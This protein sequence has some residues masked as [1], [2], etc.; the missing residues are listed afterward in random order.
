[1]ESGWFLENRLKLEIIFRK[2]WTIVGYFCGNLGNAGNN[3]LLGKIGR[4][5]RKNFAKLN[6]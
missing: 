6:F 3:Y 4:N 5:C 2:I 1:M